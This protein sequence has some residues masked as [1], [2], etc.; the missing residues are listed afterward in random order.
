MERILV[1]FGSVGNSLQIGDIYDLSVTFCSVPRETRSSVTAKSTA[2]PLC[3][4]GV[5]YDISL[6]KIC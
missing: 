1:K 2:H 4:V 6:K 3:S 5:L